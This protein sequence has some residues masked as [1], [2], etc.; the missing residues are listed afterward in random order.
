MM[1]VHSVPP[2]CFVQV[3]NGTIFIIP[4]LPE[5]VNP[6][7]VFVDKNAK[8]KDDCDLHSGS[9]Y[10]II[11]TIVKQDM[12]GFGCNTFYLRLLPRH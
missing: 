8:R 1:V 12:G 10:A 4:P 2:E 11:R 9:R 5:I 3:F 6:V 7:F